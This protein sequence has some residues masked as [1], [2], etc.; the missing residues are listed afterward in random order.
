MRL[1]ILTESYNLIKIMEPL[2]WVLSSI[3]KFNSYNLLNT[4]EYY[5]VL[6][7]KSIIF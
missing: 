3:Q 5:L 2:A 1:S 7:W 4:R 6:E